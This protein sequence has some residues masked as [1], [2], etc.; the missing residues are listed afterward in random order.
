VWRRHRRRTARGAGC[1][2][3]VPGRKTVVV[4][5]DGSGMYTSQALWSMA[6]E[7]ADVIVVVLKND[8]Y[9]ILEVE[10]ARVREGDANHKMMSMMHLNDRRSIGQAGRGHGVPAAAQRPPRN[11]TASS[12]LRCAVRAAPDRGSGCR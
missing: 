2:H 4:Q 7:K 12:R 5:G 6:R 10:L 11:F 9:A 1:R 8:S 3:C